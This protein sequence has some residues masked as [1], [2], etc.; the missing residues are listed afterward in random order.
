MKVFYA[1]ALFVV[2]ALADDDRR[3][4]S[5]YCIDDEDTLF[6]AAPYTSNCTFAAKIGGCYEAVPDESDRTIADICCE[7]CSADDEGGR[8]ELGWGSNIGKFFADMFKDLIDDVMNDDEKDEFKEDFWDKHG[9]DI[10]NFEDDTGADSYEGEGG[11]WVDMDT[12]VDEFP[13]LTAEEKAAMTEEQKEAALAIKEE[14]SEDDEDD[15]N[16]GDEEDDRRQLKGPFKSR[17]Q[18]KSKN[19]DFGKTSASGR[20]LLGA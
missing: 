13:E 20:R 9:D 14:N 15:G 8:R 4:L 18:L 10:T 2:L 3:G 16:D 5:E 11:E 19:F 7:S 17:R 1:I 12:N 6:E